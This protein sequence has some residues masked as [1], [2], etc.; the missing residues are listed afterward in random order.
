M[1]LGGVEDAVMA[2][3]THGERLCIVLEGIWRGL[4]ALVGDVKRSALL[5]QHKVSVRSGA[6]DAPRSDVPGDAEVAYESLVTHSV[7]LANGYVVAF[8]V[9]DAGERKIADRCKD[10]HGSNNDFDGAPEAGTIEYGLF[11]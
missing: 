10:D 9:T 1:K 3:G 6:P 5:E 4:G 11:G 2:V 7:E 8:V